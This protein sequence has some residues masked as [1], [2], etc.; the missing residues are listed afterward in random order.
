MPT[1]NETCKILKALHAIQLTTLITFLPTIFNQLFTLLIVT[2]SEEIGLNIIRVLINLVNMLYEANRRDVLHSYVKYVF[3]MNNDI[4]KNCGTVHE[5]MCKHL[6]IILHPN[7][8]DFLV[9]NKFMHHSDFFFDV[10]IKSMA[11]HLL[12]SGRIKMH[13][14]E[15]FSTDYVQ[16]VDNLMQVLIP[17]ILNK[18]KEMP[19]ETKELNKSLANFL[20]KCLSLM[21]RG[22]VFKLINN[23]MD[24]FNP[25]DNRLLQEYKFTFLE[26]IC[27]HEHYISFNLPIQYTKLSPKN[28]SPEHHSNEFCLSEDFCRHHFL[29]GLLLQEV[30]TALYEVP[31]I[32]K[33][34]LNTLRNLIA[35][36]ELDDR[37]E[38]KGQM[39]RIAFIYMPW[40]NVVLEN[41][42]RLEVFDKNDDEDDKSG[43]NLVSRISSSSSYLFGKSNSNASDVTP[44]SH[45]FTLHIDKDSPMH[46]RNSVFF[47]AIAGQSLVNGN[48]MSIDSDLSIISAD[49]PSTTSQETTII[50]GGETNGETKTPKH[51]RSTS[52][53]M[54][55]YDKLQQQEVRDIL[56][57]F[58][59]VV[60][61]TNEEQL[62]S[63]WQQQPNE[64]DLINFFTILEISLHCFRYVGK[65]NI[66]VI[67]KP[68]QTENSKSAATKK[69]H[70]LP[71][72]MNPS[73]I[74]N[75]NG[76]LVTYTMNRE[77]LVTSGW[78]S[79]KNKLMY[80]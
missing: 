4:K 3:I 69:A 63:W 24:K 59:F 45:R 49:A 42:N 66:V 20:K 50:R 11:Q 9:V 55:R 64:M 57:V 76:T 79:F 68:V 46:L 23:Y 75:E 44:R 52:S 56:L 17:Y 14:N 61:Y 71:A 47:D 31:H 15:R 33:I 40:L 38:S 72:R 74:G 30:R 27:N 34:S 78:F 26:I 7:N 43:E 29:V 48:S 53:Q 13:R 10:I 22:I 21:D 16:K 73:D 8:T 18:H 12:N 58:L 62:L 54:P 32:R 37:Y 51:G 36:H 1:E 65:R 35:K 5:E 39:N 77:N 67:K 2:Q 28:R 6:P 80:W 60:K 70:T 25:G 19:V 41:L